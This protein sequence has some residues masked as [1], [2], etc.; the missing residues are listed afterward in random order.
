MRSVCNTYDMHECTS[1]REGE[2]EGKR[3][4]ECPGL[5]VYQRATLAARV[6]DSHSSLPGLPPFFHVY[7]KTLALPRRRREREGWGEKER[8]ME[9]ESEGRG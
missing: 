6:T 7:R 3:G 9:G 8:E 4:W 1:E 2:R 5:W